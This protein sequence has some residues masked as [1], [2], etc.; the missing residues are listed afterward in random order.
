MAVSS[1]SLRRPRGTNFLTKA[2]FDAATDIPASRRPIVMQSAL[3]AIRDGIKFEM[4]RLRNPVRRGR[5]PGS[6]NK[7]KN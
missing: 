4:S 5:P 2:F 1:G 3:N 6:K 7:P